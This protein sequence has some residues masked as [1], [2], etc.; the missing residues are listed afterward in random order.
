MNTV[1]YLLCG[2]LLMGAF[3]AFGQNVGINENGAA[4]HTSAIL[5]VQS[6]NKGLLVPRMTSAQRAAVPGPATGLMV[7]DTTTNGFWF[8][9]GTVWVPFLSGT[10]SGNTLDQAYNQGGAGV[11]RTI[12]ANT[13]AVQ[14]AGVD[15]FEVTGTFNSGSAIVPAGAGARMFYNPRKSAIRAGYVSGTQWDNANVG[16]YSAAFG[17]SNIASGARAFAVGNFNTASGDDAVALGSSNTAS[18]SASFVLGNNSYATGSYSTALGDQSEA[19][20]DNSFAGGSSAVSAGST[21][22]AFGSNASASN[23]NTV[24]FGINS[25][26]SGAR[27]FAFGTN[28]ITES[29][30]SMAIGRFNIGGGNLTNWVF[31]DPVFE[32]GIGTSNSNRY[33]ALTVL[34]NGRVGIGI[35]APL[36][37]LH[38][39]GSLRF[40]D[41]NQA[42]GR[43]LTSDV[44]GVATWQAAPASGNTLDG[45]Y[46]FGG[47]GVG[48]TITAN[49][50][51]VEIVGL[52]GFL[53]SGT[54]GSGANVGI[55]G[56]GTRMFFN[57]RTGAFRA[58]AVAG[59]EWDQANLG[60]NSFATGYNTFATT[61]GVA[62][63]NATRAEGFASVAMGEFSTSEGSFSVAL[64]ANA[65]A[66]GESAIAIGEESTANGDLSVAFSQGTALGSS[67]I[68]HGQGVSAYSG[69]EV[70][71]GRYNTIY[72]PISSGGFDVNDRAFVI[73]NG[74]SNALRRNALTVMKNGNVGMG[75]DTPSATLHV[76]GE[77]RYV[78]GSEGV[79]KTL[80]SDA[81]GNATWSGPIGF[82]VFLSTSLSVAAATLV[83]FDGE[84]FD[85]GNNYDDALGIFYVPYS[86]LYSF[87]YIEYNTMT[88]VT[89]YGMR[90][91]VNGTVE[92]NYTTVKAIGGLTEAVTFSWTMVLDAGD[93]VYI[94]AIGTPRDLIGGTSNFINKTR[95]DGTLIK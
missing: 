33:N 84:E 94:V 66:V 76:D 15:G 10:I 11:G 14:I 61:Y 53:V 38:L 18:G 68:A 64:G 86:G 67:S 49:A 51:A 22:F 25:T 65:T 95:W 54:A 48:R 2:F 69:Y 1:S 32:I 55:S 27:S 26:A 78:D 30:S 9:N 79:N 85:L 37:T 93:L 72:T 70:A 45:A 41:G 47:A 57:P 71:F 42:A 75:T 46:D 44:N 50:G 12:T 31:E 34:K 90:V 52:D 73:G 56:A 82:S 7:F 23:S 77:M 39:I 59:A 21:S 81:N 62:M 83:H 92:R 28:I 63:G 17:N 19:N 88:T 13:G 29:F 74:T 58:G 3:S 16:N 60:S 8:Y 4:P 40:V 24:V 6:L 91:L 5:H 20:G 89:Q 36:N 35:A 87:N 43:V 80:T